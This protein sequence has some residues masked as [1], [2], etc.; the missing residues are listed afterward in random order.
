VAVHQFGG[1]VLA[2]DQ[3]SSAHFAMPAAAIGRDETVDAVLPVDD[4]AQALIALVGAQHDEAP[5]GEPL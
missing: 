1:T 2:A 4:I 3:V 5:V